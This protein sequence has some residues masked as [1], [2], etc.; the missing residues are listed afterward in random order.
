MCYAAA[1]LFLSHFQ[2]GCTTFCACGC[3]GKNCC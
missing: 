2:G 1:V 3:K